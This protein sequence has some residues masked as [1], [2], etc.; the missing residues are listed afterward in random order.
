MNEPP[1]MSSLKPGT[2]EAENVDPTS[3]F[4]SATLTS[5]AVPINSTQEHCG[6]AAVV[7]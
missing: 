4:T 6:E 3:Q 1:R 7:E 5:K 2:S